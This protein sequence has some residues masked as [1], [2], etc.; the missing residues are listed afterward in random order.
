MA[1]D[2]VTIV[3]T[4]QNGQAVRAFRDT[5]GRLR[6]MRGRF[7]TEGNQMTGAMNR[8]ATSIGGVKGSLIPLAAAAVPVAAAFAPIA[9]K[10]GGAS[11]A[12]AAF[13]IAAAG[14]ASSLKAASEA[15]TKYE[16]AV[17]KSGRGSKQAAEAQRAATAA[18]AGM[19]EAT[20]RAAIGMMTL[21]DQYREFS[22]STAKFTMA[23]VEKSFAVLGEIM[24]RLT[25]MVKGS[26]EQLDR[27]VTLAGGAVGSPGFDAFA[28]RVSAF[29]N[30]SLTGA[31]DGVVRFARA[32]SEGNATGPIASF[33]EYARQNGPAMRETLSTVAD[34]VGNLVEAAADAG[35][36][37]LT[38]VNAAAGLVAALPPGVV[39]VL[40]QTAVALKAVSLA[41]AA[42]TA[43]AGGV[44]SLGARLTALGAASAAA[45]GGLAG[46][47]AALNTMGTGGKVMLAAGAVGALVLAMHQLSDNKG[48]VAVDKLATSLNALTT[49]GKVTGE[50]K[51]NFTEMSQS[52]A[53][54]SKGA[55]DNKLAQLTSDFGTFVGISTGPGISDARKNVDAWDKSM[56]GLVKSGNTEQAAAQYEILKKAWVAGGG[57]LDRL[58]KFTNDYDDALADAKF[59]QQMA[60]ESMGVFGAAAQET[61]AKLAAQQEASDGLR[62]SILALNDVNRSAYD[63]QIGFE[64]SLDSLTESF[65]QHGA[66]LNLDT[67]AGRANATAMSAAAKSQDEMIASGLA[68]GESLGSMVGKSDELRESMMRLATDAFDGN[69]A[70][71]TEYVNTLLGVPSE[72]KTMIEA[73][74]DE[75]ISGLHDVQSAIEATPGSKSVK[76]DTLNGAAIAALE[77]VGLKTKQLPDGR[78][79]VYTAN[80][81]SLGS[82]G[83]V[84]S[85]LSALNG[86]TANTYTHHSVTTTYKN[87]ETFRASHGRATG[88][89]APGYAS[90]GAVQSYPDGGLISGPGTPT[91]DSILMLPPGG[92]MYRASDREYIVRAAAVDKY[93]VDFL[94]ALNSGRLKIAGYAKGGVTKKEREA[95]NAA[96]GDLTISHFG[97]KAGYK[98]SEIRNDLGSPDSLGALVSS[99]NQWRSSILKSTHGSQERSLL[100]QLDSY[101]KTLIK[102]ERALA[103]VN[104]SLEKAKDKLDNLKDSAAQLSASVKSGIVS[105]ANIT[106]AAGAEDSQVTI[107][108]LLSNM[109]AS[110]ANS[111][112]FD[113]M[114]KSLKAKGLRGD[115]IEQIAEAGI[116]GGGMETAAAVLGGG[117]SEIKRMNEL[118][119]QITANAGAAGKTAADAMYGAAIK[120]QESLVKS[121]TKQQDKLEKAMDK[122]ASAME[123]AIEKAYGKKAAGGIIGAASGG[124]RSRRTWVGESGPELLDL[125]PGARVW[126][127]PDSQRMAQPAWASMLNAPRGGSHAARRAAGGGMQPIV[128]HQTIAI[129]GRVVAQQIFDPMRKE[130]ANRGGN[131]QDVLGRRQG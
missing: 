43:I 8:V 29:A 25:P 94:D 44:A 7:I 108:T 56:A 32:L 128:V 77:A 87:I 121:L 93:G 119:K 106:K 67:E 97:Q 109:T 51:A 89:L 62:A 48:P 105:G 71:A 22:D 74:K 104:K 5:E 103:T 129:D 40:M 39:T 81:Q 75:A 122:L 60:A 90:G 114:L 23:P 66:T 68:A 33:M 127:N 126:S 116:G 59:E 78:T 125:P 42:A 130:I 91:S 117:S 101:G 123:K 26:S 10:A 20:Q 58:K 1:G 76:V 57:D 70:K 24:P 112:Q 83:A 37:M 55:S 98:N 65:A 16:D 118:Q 45:G 36:G 41:G 107:N 6:D 19:P 27:L 80:G 30:D 96:R 95:R 61:S 99:L 47:N 53:M 28:D 4:A 92:G 11:L 52:I 12:V 100:R 110:A 15:Q 17:V 113:S 18:L 124:I 49:T 2:D 88:G 84:S 31:V 102:Q 46:M 131:V 73:E 9:A 69:K 63:A 111:K 82:I 21:K 34:A 38:L 85:A 115:L 35:P 3:I 54:V 79:Q 120:S 14:Q 64:A 72:I 86:R 50:L 13:G